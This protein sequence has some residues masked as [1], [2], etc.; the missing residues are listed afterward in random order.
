M[1]SV[2]AGS[3]TS[4]IVR[5]AVLADTQREMRALHAESPVN[6]S[7][8]RKNASKVLPPSNALLLIGA[9]SMVRR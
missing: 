6:G 5:P 9:E 7:G 3:S 2:A 1:E 8:S 4:P